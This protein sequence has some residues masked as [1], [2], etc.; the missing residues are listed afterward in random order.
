MSIYR[1]ESAAR[2]LKAGLLADFLMRQRMPADLAATMTPNQ[3]LLV[4]NLARIHPPSDKTCALALDA[5]RG[6][7]LERHKDFQ[8]RL[9]E[10]EERTRPQTC[11][12][13]SKSKNPGRK[14]APS[15][16]SKHERRIQKPSR[17]NR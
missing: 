15:K 17:K 8:R 4:A 10:L 3:W 7:E 16:G 6:K 2:E 11:Q 12:P 9:R 14:V 13:K 5:L 1:S